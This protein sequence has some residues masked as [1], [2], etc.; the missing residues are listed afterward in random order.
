METPSFP[1]QLFERAP[2][3]VVGLGLLM[4]LS[5]VGLRVLEGGKHA[6]GA[7]PPGLA[8]ELSQG[9]LLD[10]V[11]RSSFGARGALQSRTY[12]VQAPLESALAELDQQLLGLGYRLMPLSPDPDYH[13]QSVTLL[14]QYEHPGVIVRIY[15][16]STP[17]RAGGVTFTGQYP[18][19]LEMRYIL[20]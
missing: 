16:L 2:Y 17:T 10:S 5:W 6:P 11:R 15:Q 1:A 3:I 14:K 4:M 12:G 7:E 18:V 19:M 8:L 9:R 13:P 20:M